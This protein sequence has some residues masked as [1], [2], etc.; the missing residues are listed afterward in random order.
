MALGRTCRPLPP[1]STNAI[2]SVQED[3][4]HSAAALPTFG[5]GNEG[6]YKHAYVVQGATTDKSQGGIEPASNAPG[7]PSRGLVVVTYSAAFSRGYTTRKTP[8][9]MRRLVRLVMISV[10]SEK[11]GELFFTPMGNTSRNTTSLGSLG[12][13]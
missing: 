10:A 4:L 11:I 3:V 2:G 1:G 5:Q 9:C 8:A 13:V 12:Q 7:P 6:I